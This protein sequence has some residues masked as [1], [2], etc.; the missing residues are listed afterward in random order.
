MLKHYFLY[1]YILQHIWLLADFTFD[2]SLLLVAIKRPFYMRLYVYYKTEVRT[3]LINLYTRSSMLMDG[4][5]RL[6]G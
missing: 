4:F 6:C 2:I 5:V 1:H 3:L